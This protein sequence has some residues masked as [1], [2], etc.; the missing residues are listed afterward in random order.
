[1]KLNRLAEW[2]DWEEEIVVSEKE[3]M[4]I[5]FYGKKSKGD[6]IVKDRVDGMYLLQETGVEGDKLILDDLDIEREGRLYGTAH[7]LFKNS[8]EVKQD[9]QVYGK[10]QASRKTSTKNVWFTKTT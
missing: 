7:E 8:N 9:Y 4:K 3:S 1:M 10:A 2:Q 5:P 6:S